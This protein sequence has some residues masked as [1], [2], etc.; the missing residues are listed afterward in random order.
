MWIR[1]LCSPEMDL[2]P[3]QEV[4]CSRFKQSDI[5]IFCYCSITQH[6]LTDTLLSYAFLSLIYFEKRNL[7]VLL[8]NIHC[9][10]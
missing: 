10:S 5:R 2:K 3:K 8:Q 4:N 1:I 7:Y 6:I 9:F